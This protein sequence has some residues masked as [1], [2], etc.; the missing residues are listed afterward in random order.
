MKDCSSLIKCGNPIPHNPSHIKE[1]FPEGLSVSLYPHISFSLVKVPFH[2]QP[3]LFLAIISGSLCL[4]TEGCTEQKGCQSDKTAGLP[5]I[6]AAQG[7]YTHRKQKQQSH[8]L[9]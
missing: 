9:Y 1:S 6:E 5:A 8:R 3:G 7:N 2:E 4:F